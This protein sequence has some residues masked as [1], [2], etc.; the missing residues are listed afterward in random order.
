M[1]L[2]TLLFVA[3]AMFVVSSFCQPTLN[4]FV[5]NGTGDFRDRFQAIETDNNGNSYIGGYTVHEDEFT[6]FL[7]LK[8]DLSGQV[9]WKREF[10]GLSDNADEIEDLVY[11]VTNDRVIVTGF[12]NSG[13]VGNDFWTIALSSEGEVLWSALYN[14]PESNQYDQPNAIAIDNQG[15]VFITG[16]CDV[17]PTSGIQKDVLTIA[18]NSNGQL[19]WA[20]KF[21]QATGLDRGEDIAYSSAGVITVCGRSSNGGNDD[22]LVLGYDI[23]GNL[24]W[25]QILDSGGTDRGTSVDVATDGS[26]YTTGRFGNGNDD[27]FY[28]L[29]IAANGSILWTRIFDFVE[30]DRADLIRVGSNGNVYVAGRSDANATAVVNYNYRV[31][32]YNAA[33]TQLWTVQYEGTGFGDDLVSAMDVYSDG[34]VAVTG[35]SDQIAGVNVSNDIV[36]VK[37]SNTGALVWT[38]KINGLQGVDDLSFD[39][40]FNSSGV[41]ETVGVVSNVANNSSAIANRYDGPASDVSLLNDGLG[42]NADNVRVVKSLLDQEYVG[43]YTVKSEDNRNA[44]LIRKTLTDTLWTRTLNGSLYGSD[45]DVVD[46]EVF[47][48]GVVVLGYLRNSGQG[49]DIFLNKYTPTGTLLWSQ[50]YNGAVSESD[51]PAELHSYNGDLYVIG[52]TDIDPLFTTN[53]QRLLLCYNPNGVLLWSMINNDGNGDD[54]NKWINEVNDVLIVAARVFNG[55]NSDVLIT[56]YYPDGTV[57]WSQTYDGG[58]NDDIEKMEVFPSGSIGLSMISY[59]ADDLTSTSVFRLISSEG[60]SYWTDSW[61]S[62]SHTY[63][64]PVQSVEFP[65]VASN[66]YYAQLVNHPVDN[67]GSLEAYSLRVVDHLGVPVAASTVVASGDL[68]GDGIIF[69]PADQQIHL[70][71]HEDIDAGPSINFDVKTQIWSESNAFQSNE[72]LPIGVVSD[73]SEIANLVGVNFLAGS[74]RGLNQ[75]D[76]FVWTW[77]WWSGVQEKKNDDVVIYPNP[78]VDE[79]TFD[80]SMSGDLVITDVSGKD[81]WNKKLRGE[82]QIDLSFLSPG[83][84]FIQIRNQQSYVIQ[85][86]I[87]K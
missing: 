62:A 56:G 21:D 14:D 50:V 61:S 52:R 16:D 74:K 54:R 18:Y 73:S 9:V 20:R 58:F 70:I 86:L 63:N 1:R 35:I 65:S 15:N 19:L 12:S 42:D 82:K 30:D 78:F 51:R 67:S 77:D 43:G 6:N 46:I 72:I 13:A 37:Y 34:A 59:S 3:N 45:D 75:R 80:R 40:A 22:Y 2:F 81:V 60:S 29:K 55:S 8:R 83:A 48:D 23:S 71:C 64:Q 68:I 5:F 85:K 31:V 57:F 27:D 66:N 53:N 10:N 25:S 79:I 32:V 38:K 24:I 33:S 87:K 17:D 84:Y 28:T 76:M 11:D 49:A 47:A 26:I 69:N 41:V 7:I 4:E 39:V 36:T 44:I